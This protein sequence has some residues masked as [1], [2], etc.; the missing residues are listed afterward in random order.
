[1]ST[2]SRNLTHNIVNKDGENTTISSAVKVIDST[3]NKHDQLKN[4]ELG[5]RL[6]L[7]GMS[8]IQ[9]YRLANLSTKMVELDNKIFDESNL[10][11]ASADQL[12]EMWRMA[13]S[14][15][16]QCT[17]YVNKTLASADWGNL[18]VQ[19]LAL[20]DQDLDGIDKSNDMSEMARTLLAQMSQ[21]TGRK[22]PTPPDDDIE[23]VE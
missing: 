20:A 3:G 5:L 12:L 13:N 16:E 23:D 19:L 2:I 1:M 4:K 7:I 11:N 15:I 8:E 21:Q 10:R 14:T 6:L 22:P 9:A 18:E 17:N